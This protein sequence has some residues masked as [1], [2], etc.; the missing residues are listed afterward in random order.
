MRKRFKKLETALQE[1]PLNDQ[2]VL[3]G[4][5][6]ADITFVTWGSQKG[7]I[8]DVME[9]LAPVNA[10]PCA[11]ATADI[12]SSVI[13]LPLYFRIDFSMLIP[14]FSFITIADLLPHNSRKR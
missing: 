13:C 2:A 9:A 12:S 6:K 8:L 4:P 11:M 7:P 1:I 3:Y 5:D 14:V 10:A